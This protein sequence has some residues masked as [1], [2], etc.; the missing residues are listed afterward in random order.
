MELIGKGF[1]AG[2]EQTYVISPITEKPLRTRGLRDCTSVVV[3]GTDAKTGEQISFI[4]HQNPKEFLKD[5]KDRFTRDFNES[6]EELKNRCVPGSID[7]VICGGRNNP[8]AVEG[9]KNSLKTLSSAINERMG[10]VPTVICGSKNAGEDDIYFKPKDRQLHIVRPDG[11][12]LDNRSFLATP[13]NIDQIK[14]AG[15]DG[16]EDLSNLH[17]S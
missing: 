15:K 14:S 12:I 6:L 13:E 2:G 10:F 8:S 4:S 16:M 17:I 9:Y 1:K 3:V 11:V 5:I 7:V